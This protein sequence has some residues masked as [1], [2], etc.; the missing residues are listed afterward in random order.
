[1]R[2]LAKILEIK[3]RMFQRLSRLLPQW[4][5]PNMLSGLRALLIIPIFPLFRHHQLG[6]VIVF[7]VIALI[8][9]VLDG[10]HARITRQ[11]S[12]IGTLLD[13]AADKIIFVGLF[14]LVA[15][16]RFSPAIIVTLISLELIL[17]LLA[18]VIGPLTARLLRVR[19]K[20]GA[21]L[22][23]KIKMTLESTALITVLLGI[24]NQLAVTVAEVLLWLAAISALIS[25]ILHL[26]A[27]EPGQNIPPASVSG[28]TD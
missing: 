7:L 26:T 21:N 6:W 22:P 19:R 12:N 15:P 23:G 16:G 27:K 3:E 2:I 13:P 11:I 8:T 5:S 17:V 28:G 1:M 9:D 14:L 10:V 18:A 4:L 24:D 25:I 20:K